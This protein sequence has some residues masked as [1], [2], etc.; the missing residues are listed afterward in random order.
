MAAAAVWVAAGTVP[1]EAEA[2]VAVTPANQLTTSSYRPPPTGNRHCDTRQTWTRLPERAEPRRAN[3]P[4]RP[5]EACINDS[6][7]RQLSLPGVGEGAPQTAP[8]RHSD[9]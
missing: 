1:A 5:A 7:R 2:G 9:H 3:R 8:R 6:R 4:C